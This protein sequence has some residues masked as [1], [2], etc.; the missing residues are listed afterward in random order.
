MM[1]GI[2]IFLC[3]VF[4]ILLFY[5]GYFIGVAY[6]TKKF[7]NAFVCALFECGIDQST[8]EKVLDRTKELCVKSMKED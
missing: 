7:A 5:A 2:V 6:M 4:S 3:I 8:A 1:T